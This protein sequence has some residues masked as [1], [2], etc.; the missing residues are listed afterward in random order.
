MLDKWVTEVKRQIDK[1]IKKDLSSIIIDL[2]EHTGG[3]MWAAIRT[4]TNIYGETTLLKFTSSKDWINIA[5]NTEINGQFMTNELKFKKPI[6]IIVS[7][8]TASSGEIIAASF[9]GRKTYIFMVIKP[10][11][12]MVSYHLTKDFSLMIK[13]I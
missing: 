7:S 4:L 2:S 11:K 8:Q 9:K 13:I 10:I 1:E 6:H 5:N 3:N 12:V